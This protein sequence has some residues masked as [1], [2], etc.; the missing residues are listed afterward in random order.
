MQCIKVWGIYN[1]NVAQEFVSFCVFL[2]IWNFKYW[3]NKYREKWK[4]KYNCMNV[5]FKINTTQSIVV[6]QSF[7]SNTMD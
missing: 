4:Q 5:L 3:R 1:R 7:N 2:D 6:E